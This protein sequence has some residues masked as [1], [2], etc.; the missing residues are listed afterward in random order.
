ME[1]WCAYIW[2]R[3]YNLNELV[4]CYQTD[5]SI[6]GGLLPGFYGNTLSHFIVYTCN[7]GH[8]VIREE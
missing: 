4:F 8:P 7:L 5:G 1:L 6:P 2:G 3:G